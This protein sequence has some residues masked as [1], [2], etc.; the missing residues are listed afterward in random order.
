[1]KVEVVR[2]WEEIR[3]ILILECNFM[4]TLTSFENIPN[5]NNNSSWLG[6]FV[7]DKSNKNSQ[8][9][10]V[11]NKNYDDFGFP[12]DSSLLNCVENSSRTLN[13]CISTKITIRKLEKNCT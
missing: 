3:L 5:L 12:F 1:M 11:Q 2:M 9:M 6:A 7:N 13:C 10:E 8:V 4:M